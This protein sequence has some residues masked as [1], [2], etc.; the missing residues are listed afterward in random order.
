MVADALVYHPA[1]AH[2]LRFV[3]TTGMYPY[4]LCCC[5]FYLWW[6]TSDACSFSTGS[7]AGIA[8]LRS[9]AH[10]RNHGL[11]SLPTVGRDKVLR[12]LQYFA[13]FFAWY[14]YRTNRPQSSIAPFE[15]IKKQF[16]L[17]R[18]ILRVGKFVEHLKAAAVAFD[19]KGPVD[20]VLRYLTVG[21][22]LGYA[23]YLFIDTVTVV[24]AI[25]VKKLATAKKL[26][27]TA[28]RAWLAG[29]VCSAVASVYTLWRLQ[30]K[31]KTVDR[32]EGEGV[33]EAKKIE[34]S[35]P[36]P[37]PPDSL[38]CFS[39][40]TDIRFCRERATTRTQLVSDL[41]DITI[42]ISSLGLANLDDGL[43]G[44]A[45]TISSLIGLHSAWK[46]TA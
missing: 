7:I 42:P 15:A 35:V 43:V 12:T 23:G 30:E 13:R 29:L 14:L 24:D 26:Q 11:T 39:G 21:R 19:N 18:K 22:Q 38:S 44:I 36:F 4:F 1:V 46:K 9:H 5:P 6:I 28:Y 31:E 45:G 37:L 33:V 32:K 10:H 25:G 2:Y 40:L 16:G 34:K 20:P 27:A 17:T 41:C 8:L 3:A